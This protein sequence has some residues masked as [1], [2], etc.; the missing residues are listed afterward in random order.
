[1]PQ[2]VFQLLSVVHQSQPPAELALWECTCSANQTTQIAAAMTNLRY[3]GMKKHSA[4]GSSAGCIPY[5]IHSPSMN[6]EP[7]AGERAGATR[8]I[9]R[10]DD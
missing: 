6:V 2:D 3:R 10:Q 8:I 5:I 1:M 7:A 4:D 9:L